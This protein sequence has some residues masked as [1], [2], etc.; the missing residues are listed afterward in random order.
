MLLLCQPVNKSSFVLFVLQLQVAEARDDLALLTRIQHKP[1]SP[2]NA[3][4]GGARVGDM[5]EAD[6]QMIP[7][8]LRNSRSF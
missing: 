2:Y 1:Q 5:A 4:K 3:E 8:K 7:P 6:M